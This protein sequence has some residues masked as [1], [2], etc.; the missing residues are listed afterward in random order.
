MPCDENRAVQFIF[1]EF[2]EE[3]RDNLASRHL[4]RIFKMMLLGDGL[5]FLVGFHLGEVF[6]QPAQ[7]TFLHADSVPWRSQIE[8]LALELQLHRA[9][10][11]LT[12]RG[13][14]IFRQ[15]HHVI[16]ICVRFV[17][18]DICKL[19]IVTRIHPLIS[20]HSS[21][22][23]DTIQPAYDESLQIKFVGNT[24]LHIQIQR[25]VVC[26]KG[27][28]VG[29]AGDHG[30]NRSFHFKIAP[31]IQ[32]LSDAFNDHSS[33]AEYLPYVFIHDEVHISLTISHVRIGQTV[34]FFRE[35]LYGFREKHDFRRSDGDLPRL[36]PEYRTFNSHDIAD[37]IGLKNLIFF[38]RNIVSGHE[39]LNSALPVL[40]VDKRYFA[41]DAFRHNTAGDR[42]VFF[43]QLFK[44]VSDI[45]AVMAHVPFFLQKRISS[46]RSQLFQLIS[47]D[48]SLLV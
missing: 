29:A 10:E 6:A 25:V 1:T 8:S 9:V 38:R 46:V 19:R 11:L 35:D 5:R 30:E 43:F 17:K 26:F 12:E 13:H 39:A 41:H 22:F 15:L 3:F 45:G 7:N 33:L 18:F 47:S 4:F 37:I 28:G 21:Q 2:F 31:V 32:E 24:Q 40:N 20:E 23:I 34:E 16:I 27:S 36:R 48:L 44:V 14:Q 42:H